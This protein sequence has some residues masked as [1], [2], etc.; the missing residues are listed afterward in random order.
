MKRKHQ[1][2][3]L[4]LS[5]STALPASHSVAAEYLWVEAEHSADVQGGNYSFLPMPLAQQRGW[6]I[7]GPGVAAEWTQGGESEWTSIAAHPEEN[8]ATSRYAI[9]VPAAG[10]YR[11]WVRYADYQ[12]KKEAFRVRVNQGGKAVFDQMFGEQAVIVEDD[13]VK[14][15]WGWAFGWG[16]AEADLQAG[17][18]ELQLIVD[19]A[20]EARR[21]V[22]AFLITD[23][24]KFRPL[25]REKPPFHYWAPLQNLRE[26]RPTAPLAA[27]A[28]NW[29]DPG[30]WRTPPIAGRYF[31]MLFNMPVTYWKQNDIAADKRVLYPFNQRPPEVEK[32][33][34]EQYGGKKDLPVWSSKLNVPVIYIASLPDFLSDDSPFLAWLKQTKSPFGILINYAFISPTES[35]GDKGPMLARNLAA[36]KDQF[37]GYMSG[38]NPGYVYTVD[39]AYM[40][41]PQAVG[42]LTHRQ[43]LLD[44]HRDAL[45]VALRAKYQR[46]YGT[47]AT[48]DS[49]WPT[50]MS[51][52][53]TDMYPYVHAFAEWGERT[54]AHEG[55]ANTPNYALSYAF[56][57]GASRQFGRNWVWYHSSN[58]GDTSTTFISGQNI[59]GPYTNYHHSHY[60]SF[61]GAGLVWYRKAYYSAYMAGAAGIY[62]EQ[63]FDQYF[64][65]S[66]GDERVQLSPF[67]RITSE[68]TRFAERHP[69]RGVPYTPIAFLLDSGHGWYQYENEAGAFG[70]P[71][72]RN[73]AVLNYSRHDAMIRDLFNIAY[74]PLPKIEGE[75]LLSPGFNFINAPLGNVFDVLVTSRAPKASDITASYRAIVLSGDVR[76]TAEWGTALRDFVQ[77]GGTLVV[78]DDQV[79]GP[80]AAVLNLPVNEPGASATGYATSARVLWKLGQTGEGESINSNTYRY[81]KNPPAGTPIAVAGDGKPIA[82][83]STVGQGKIIWIGVPK[84]LGLDNRA[85]PLMSKIMLHLRQ[86]LLPVEVRGD[87]EYS[88]NRNDT[89]WIVTLFNNR[90]N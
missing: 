63:G 77:R 4:A 41:D 21:G 24:L 55:A 18:A 40:L 65:P 57:R 34:I 86:G 1:L 62:L 12:K 5:L 87:V 66:P 67:G 79:Q 28:A 60:D 30:A 85:T 51:A 72:K 61:S 3:A 10:R 11:V 17:P 64:I 27:P 68:F 2:F 76:L 48:T 16:M 8:N 90:G 15:M 78:T 31:Q 32:K 82:V 54:L 84:G 71:A 9:E 58:F 36:L 14:L 22:D 38:E 69:N 81:R 70:V 20:S 74:Y 46:I 89:G 56:L 53:S 13:E 59:A 23:D 39:Y 80:G 50:L 7:A 29:T 83:Q 33:F 43:Q 26:V 19:A 44:L 73:P 49:P 75:P 45:T 52:M 35:F 6:G 88:V 25:L 37:V 42:K 47:P